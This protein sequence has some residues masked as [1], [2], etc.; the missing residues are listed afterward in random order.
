MLILSK[1]GKTTQENMLQIS[2]I[3]RGI[4]ELEGGSDEHLENFNMFYTK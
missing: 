4:L 2:V 1:S 3:T